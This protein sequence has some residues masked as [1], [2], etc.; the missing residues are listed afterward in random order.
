MIEIEKMFLLSD[1]DKRDSFRAQI[2]NKDLDEEYLFSS[3][4]IKDVIEFCWLQGTKFYDIVP[5]G[6]PS[7]YLVSEKLQSILTGS[8]FKGYT[9]RSIILKNKRNELVP[10]YQLLSICSKVGP[11]LN[12]KSIKIMMPPAVPWGDPYEA[13]VGLYFDLSTWDGS[14]FFFPEGTSYIFVVEEVKKLFEEHKVTNCQFD[15]VIDLE[16][17]GIR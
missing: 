2:I 5:T 6:Y 11:I 15:K 13:Y 9:L 12:E 8:E 3:K 17:Y 10:G 7:V 14:H 4:E 1:S 16:N